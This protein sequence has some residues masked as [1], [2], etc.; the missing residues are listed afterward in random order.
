[1]VYVAP[2]LYAQGIEKR[3]LGI[4]SK[5]SGL[6]KPIVS[7][8]Y[9]LMPGDSILITI[10]G[11]T[12]YSYVTVVTYEGKVSINIP[13][14][15]MPMAQ[16]IYTPQYDIVAA[17]PMY[18]L[19]LD[20]AKDSLKNVFLKYF[21]NVNIDITLLSLRTFAIF[22]V[23]EVVKPGI[24]FARPIDRASTVIDSV[25][26]V[27][28]V[29][30]RSRIELRRKGSLY[31]LVDLKE[32][33]R[34]GNTEVNPYVQDGDIINVPRM[35]K[36]VVVRG[37]V[38]GKRAYEFE[39]VSVGKPEIMTPIEKMSQ[40]LYELLEG[41]TVSD[42]VTKAGGVTPWTDLSS[43]YIERDG[44]KIMINLEEV[45]ADENS[46]Y[47][48]VM[49]DGDVLY[50]PSI[51]TV[52]YVEGL[53][54]NP[55]PVEFQPNLKASDYIG[56]AGGPVEG[57]NLSS[58]YVERKN[59]KTAVKDDPIIEPGDRIFVPRHVLM[60]WQDH[61]EIIAVFASLLISYL[62]VTK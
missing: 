45:L 27:T 47:N 15:S 38:Y 40:G 4:G 61:L 43:V 53:V 42:I 41:E 51:T 56:L 22:V 50:I 25:G 10:T 2:S 55:G 21:R 20:S 26:G 1:M 34:T 48:I 3:G 62:S 54:A 6:E 36:S 8:E 17:V 57:A 14:A 33:E 37:A 32:F 5:M 23:G 7:E 18:N 9:M 44:H 11:A 19:S 49:E 13:V 24:A 35:E 29:G 30:S 52:V 12:H 60:F 59:K 46:G 31:Q 39:E 28:D 16:G 58:A